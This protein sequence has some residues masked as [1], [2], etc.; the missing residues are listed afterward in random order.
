MTVKNVKN[1]ASYSEVHAT[2]IQLMSSFYILKQDDIHVS[3]SDTLNFEYNIMTLSEY[4]NYSFLDIFE[5]I[6]NFYKMGDLHCFYRAY[7]HTLYYFGAI[8]F[9]EDFCLDNITDRLNFDFFENCFGSEII[10][11]FNLVKYP[12]DLSESDAKL[13]ID[14]ENAIFEYIDEMH[15]LISSD[16]VNQ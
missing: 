8:R 14:K 9:C 11:I 6:E 2:Y 7:K 13:I 15:Q 1:I 16:P 4:L 10:D 5:F 12:F 3:L